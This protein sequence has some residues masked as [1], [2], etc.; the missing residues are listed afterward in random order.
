MSVSNFAQGLKSFN[1]GF[2]HSGQNNLDLKA[3]KPQPVE[4]QRYRPVNFHHSVASQHFDHTSGHHI[5]NKAL[6]RN[7]NVQKSASNPPTPRKQEPKRYQMAS[8]IMQI[9]KVYPSR[10]T[11][12]Q[13]NSLESSP[14]P[15]Q[16]GAN[17]SNSPKKSSPS[18]KQ[19][20]ISN[21]VHQKSSDPSA[22]ALRVTVLSNKLKGRNRNLAGVTNESVEA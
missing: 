10:R 11:K 4:K 18:I 5:S 8:E 9:V 6:P 19:I 22:K 7:L 3:A 21:H 16:R 12:P 14:S 2:S 20:I 13:V 17:Q 15:R 1:N